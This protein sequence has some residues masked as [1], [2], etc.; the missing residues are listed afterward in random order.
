M[1]TE[2]ELRRPGMARPLHA[3]HSAVI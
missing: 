2:P 3:D 1:Y